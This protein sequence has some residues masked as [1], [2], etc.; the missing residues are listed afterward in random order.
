EVRPKTAAVV[1]A[2]CRVGTERNFPR[3]SHPSA[4][5]PSLNRSAYAPGQREDSSTGDLAR[6][7]VRRATD[8]DPRRIM[9]P[10]MTGAAL[11]ARAVVIKR[12]WRLSGPH[13]L[14][15]NELAC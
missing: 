5:A 14:F 7:G 9:P 2:L 12:R 3:I 10:S 4:S 11:L 13:D 15:V 8:A 6:T 1:P